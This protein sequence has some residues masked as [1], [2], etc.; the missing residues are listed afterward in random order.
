M[1]IRDSASAAKTKA[2][3]SNTCAIG[4]ISLNGQV[5]TAPR[6][7]PRLREAARL[8]YKRAIIC[9]MR[10]KISVPGLEIIEVRTV[11]EALQALGL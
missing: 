1:C 6:M 10:K 9:P 2:V 4:E 7:E 3:K 11:R 8:G 5:R